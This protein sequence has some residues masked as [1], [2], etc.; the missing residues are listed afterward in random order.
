MSMKT[1]YPTLTDTKNKLE[2]VSV[3]MGNA[4]TGEMAPWLGAL[5]LSVPSPHMAANNHLSTPV[6]GEYDA[7]FWP[8]QAVQPCDIQTEKRE[9]LECTNKN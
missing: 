7:I 9:M 2:L 5:T 8:L 1:I 3:K 4:A 6:P